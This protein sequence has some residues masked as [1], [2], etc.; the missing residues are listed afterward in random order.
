[1]R[2]NA[3]MLSR[4][5]A[6][7]GTELR[8]EKRRRLFRGFQTF[9]LLLLFP[10]GLWTQNSI[11][12]HRETEQLE[13]TAVAK[14]GVPSP[15]APQPIAAGSGRKII[16]EFEPVAAVLVCAI[17]ENELKS[18]LLVNLV[19]ALH[20]KSRVIILVNDPAQI[21]FCRKL[22]S[23]A[24][25]PSGAVDLLK[26]NSNSIWLRDYGPIFASEANG[27]MVA[28]EST[29]LLGPRTGKAS[30]NDEF[31]ITLS[32]LL[33]LDIDSLPIHLEGGNFVSNGNGLVCTTS[34][35]LSKNKARG[36]DGKRINKLFRRKF[37]DVKWIM[38]P[39]LEGEPTGHAD[40]FLNFLSPD[41]VV[42][43]E[44]NSATEPTNAATLDQLADLLAKQTIGEQPLKVLRVPLL[45]DGKVWRSF[46]NVLIVNNTILVP[47]FQDTPPLIQEAALAVYRE[48]VPDADVIAVP[49]D[50]LLGQYGLL[51][52]MS[53]TLPR[54]ID[55][56]LLDE[57]L[58]SC[59]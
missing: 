2:L 25:I 3:A 28:L 22:L 29:Y 21:T 51:H 43:G 36:F 41:T 48:A 44:M 11:T 27:E 56:Q 31:A 46:C 32:N 54:G 39:P 16:A 34:I 50:C 58:I 33:N 9:L 19:K 57:M 12:E 18:Q 40:I 20:E 49:C 24:G 4:S 37:G 35:V 38:T 53:L 10:L 59:P 30:S 15:S 45:R 55:T 8:D 14:P 17:A 7:A 23:K 52:C 26:C 1:M 5:I 13:P 42:V 6:D 47:S